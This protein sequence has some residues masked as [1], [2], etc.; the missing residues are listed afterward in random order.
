MMNGAFLNIIFLIFLFLSTVQYRTYLYPA[1]SHVVEP[2]L[3]HRFV[4]RT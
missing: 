4:L 1:R 2:T 3:D